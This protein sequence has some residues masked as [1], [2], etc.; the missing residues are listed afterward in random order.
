MPRFANSERRI[1]LGS[2]VDRPTDS[3][4]PP[5]PSSNRTVTVEMVVC[6]EQY[7]CASPPVEGAGLWWW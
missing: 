1:V 6:Y 7:G 3:S 4:Y 2:R 5:G